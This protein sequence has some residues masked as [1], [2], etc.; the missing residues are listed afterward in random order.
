MESRD[1]GNFHC[2]RCGNRINLGEKKVTLFVSVDEIIDD[3]E[4]RPNVF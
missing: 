1:T 3:G 4:Y 2:D